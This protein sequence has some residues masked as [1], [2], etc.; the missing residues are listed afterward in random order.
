MVRGLVD[1]ENN[2]FVIEERQVFNN[3]WV[4]KD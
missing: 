4:F 1:G 3:I 2:I